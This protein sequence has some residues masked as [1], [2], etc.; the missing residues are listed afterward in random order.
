MLGAGNNKANISGVEQDFDSSI[1]DVGEGLVLGDASQEEKK[2]TN[3][4]EAL[5]F[6]DTKPKKSKTKSQATEDNNQ[7]QAGINFEDTMQKQL[8]AN[9][10]VFPKT[11]Q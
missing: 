11:K 2:E 9:P 4:I 1:E 10:N 8:H 5:Q 3:Y 6:T 7:R